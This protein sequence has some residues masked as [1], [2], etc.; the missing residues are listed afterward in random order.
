MISSCISSIKLTD[1]EIAHNFLR[2]VVGNLF[3]KNQFVRHN[4]SSHLKI[5]PKPFFFLQIYHSSDTTIYRRFVNYDQTTN[6]Q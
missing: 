3:H 5:K 6:L 2:I 4:C 1:R